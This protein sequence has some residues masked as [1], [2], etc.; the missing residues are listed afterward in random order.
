MTLV[1]KL[2]LLEVLMAA[3]ANEECCTK[4]SNGLLLLVSILNKGLGVALCSSFLCE[5]IDFKVVSWPCGVITRA[6]MLDDGFAVDCLVLPSGVLKLL[7]IMLSVPALI[8]AVLLCE[9]VKKL[10]IGSKVFRSDG[11]IL[12]LL[13]VV[14]LN[15]VLGKFGLAIGVPNTSTLLSE[16]W[17][18]LVY[19]FREPDSGKIAVDLRK[20]SLVNVSNSVCIKLRKAR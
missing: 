6:F 2:S 5:V 1:E 10:L 8:V 20:L 19:T 14:A 15:D 17:L 7:A 13:K 9:L 12:G 11:S 18:L 16:S 3:S 4:L